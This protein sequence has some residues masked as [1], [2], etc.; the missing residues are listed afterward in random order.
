MALRKA[1]I[2]DIKL[3]YNLRNQPDV[4]NYSENNKKKIYQQHKL[5]FQLNF[6]KKNNFFFCNYIKV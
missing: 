5:W 3:F 6:K 2:S 4:R 1:K